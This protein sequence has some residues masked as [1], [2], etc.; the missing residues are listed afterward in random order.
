MNKVIFLILV[1]IPISSFAI[2]ASVGGGARPT[3]MTRLSGGVK[4]INK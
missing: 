1:G 2:G 4:P 3:G